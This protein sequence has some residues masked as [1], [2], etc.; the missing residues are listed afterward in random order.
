MGAARCPRRCRPRCRGG[1]ACPIKAWLT[2]VPSASGPAIADL[3][4]NK[5]KPQMEAWPSSSRAKAT[6]SLRMAA[7]EAGRS[8]MPS[9]AAIRAST[10]CSVGSSRY[11]GVK[12][13]RAKRVC[14]I[15][16]SR[17]ALAPEPE[18]RPVTEIF[19]ATPP[20]A[21]H[22]PEVGE[23]ARSSF[24]HRPVGVPHLVTAIVRDFGQIWA[25]LS[26]PAASPGTRKSELRAGTRRSRIEYAIR[27]PTRLDSLEGRSA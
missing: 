14:V 12:P 8:P 20:L 1:A 4:H 16:E 6:P 11:C 24:R 10:S 18:E 3:R 25:K 15:E 5:A 7:K 13:K 23:L 19:S 26:M 2:P 22:P 21:P 9:P 17:I 27:F